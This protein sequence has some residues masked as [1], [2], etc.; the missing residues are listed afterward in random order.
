VTATW[1]VILA[2]GEGKRMRS[3]R[4][5]VL[6]RLAGRPLIEYPVALT[7]AVGARG[8]VVVV[9][10]QGDQVRAALGG[11]ADLAFAEQAEPRG[12]GH[13]LAQAKGFISGDADEVLVL[14]GDVPLLSSTTVGRLLAEHRRVRAVATLLTFAPADPSGYGRILRRVGARG[15]I[16]GVVE[17]RDATARERRI[18][19]VNA[20][21][22]VF[23]PR[24]L[25]PALDRLAPANDQ[26][27]LYLTDVVEH[28]AR[29][30]R[31]LAAVR[32]EDPI[33]VAG[34]NDRRQL[35][36]LEGVLRERT[37]ARLMLEGV[38]VLDPPSTYVGADVTVDRDTV[39][40]PGVL[41]EGRTV[42]G[43]GSIVGMG[44]QL[45]DVVLGQRVTL[46]PYCVLVDAIVEDGAEVGPFAHLRPG[47]V[48]RPKAKI[49]N[50]V[51]LK[52]ATV[53]RGAKVPHLSYVGD[54]TVGEEANV[55]AGTITCNYDGVRKHQTRIGARAFVGT[56]ASLVAP[57][58]I[59]DG[60]Y[61][62]AG[63]VITQDVPPDALAL[64][65]AQQVVKEGWAARRRARSEGA[66]G[67]A[68]PADRA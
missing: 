64:G 55:G 51:E 32:V 1:V 44:C 12:T 4:A 56:N 50:F 8:I 46:R 34:V 29:A 24:L 13:A 5:K 21:V 7:R 68:P 22:Y 14:S 19:E 23:D 39:L 26:G 27:E 54:A 47:S 6:H 16:R 41:L 20:G 45:T 57:L 36:Q 3:A 65:R 35:A 60:A 58:T 48:V 17:E 42:V 63:S 43:A 18:R 38:T 30:R 37:L 31:R 25:W 10:H 66:E 33:E 61:V 67:H 28:F 9:G 40:Y 53:G 15:P 11:A 62:A 52:K 59:G 2:A 49:G